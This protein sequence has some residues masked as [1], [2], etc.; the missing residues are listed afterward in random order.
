MTQAS[1][2]WILAGFIAAFTVWPFVLVLRRR[3]IE[4]A[5]HA[6]I[7]VQVSLA[8]VVGSMVAIT[9]G[10]VQISLGN[11]AY[12]AVIMTTAAMFAATRQLRIVRDAVV[13]VLAVNTVSLV[14]LTLTAAALERSATSLGQGIPASAFAVSVPALIVGTVLHIAGILVLAWIMERARALTRSS[15]VIAAATLAGFVG[16]LAFDGVAFPTLSTWWQPELGAVLASGWQ[17]VAGKLLL[18]VAFGVP[19]AIFLAF[20]QQ[21]VTDQPV[22]LDIRHLLFAPRRDLL[23]RLTAAV[24]ASDA[25]SERLAS[26]MDRVTEGVISLDERLRVTFAN[27]PAVE[28]LGL[29]TPPLGQALDQAVSG[30]AAHSPAAPSPEIA[31]LERAASTGEPDVVVTDRIKPGR[32]IEMRLFPAAGEITVFIRDVTE[33]LTRRRQLEELA[34]AEQRAAAQLRELDDLKNS[35][36]TA[37]SHELRTPLTVARGLAETIQRAEHSPTPMMS[38]SDRIAV[39]DALADNT[40]RLSRLL[41]DLLDLDRLL[42]GASSVTRSRHDLASLVRGILNDLPMEIPVVL[43]APD[44][45]DVEVDRVRIERIFSNLLTNAIKYAEATTV[46]IRVSAVGSMARIEVRDRGPG[47]PKDQL[48]KVFEPFH[49]SDHDHPQPGTGI[50]LTLVREFAILHGGNA[51]A[52]DTGGQ[53]A[54]F[55]VEIPRIMDPAELS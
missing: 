47:I 9:V 16:V 24:A 7:A 4:P 41:D 25:L 31:A 37:V 32:A 52:V 46:T 34:V 42:R 18:G 28:L 44:R 51:W 21:P 49:R 10:S 33:E 45:L 30:L 26:T 20:N 6:T 3:M 53:G 27:K 36:L 8:G 1:T 35:F 23:T 55:I 29:A 38:T 13:L 22:E 11:I 12:A 2:W 15:W 48:E 14:V 5:F 54:H 43:E 50:G 17:G 19:L 39:V 40:E